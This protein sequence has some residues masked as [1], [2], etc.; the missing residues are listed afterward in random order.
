MKLAFENYKNGISQEFPG[1]SFEK[2]ISQG[3]PSDILTYPK[4]PKV[5]RGVGIPDETFEPARSGSSNYIGI[6][7]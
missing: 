5:I 3:N 6:I 4:I 1:T 7:C 2:W